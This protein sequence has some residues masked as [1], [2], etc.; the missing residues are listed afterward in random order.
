MT[1][2]DE[3]KVSFIYHHPDSGMIL[4]RVENSDEL[5]VAMGGKLASLTP[6]EAAHMAAAILNS[7]GYDISP[8]PLGANT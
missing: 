4:Y 3:V 6:Q 5:S 2:A 7:Y 8:W 1:Q